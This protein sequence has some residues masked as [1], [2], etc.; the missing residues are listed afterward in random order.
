MFEP[1]VSTPIS[2]HDRARRVAQALVLLVGQRHRR[3]DG[4]RVAG[5]HAHR[6][7]VLDRADD[8]EVVGA[9]ADD[10]ELELLPAEQALL[11]QALV[12]RALLEAPS[13]SP[14]SN[15]LAS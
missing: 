1:P 12:R 15:S 14:S 3:R 6:V 13:G 4:D 2:V 7:D 9:V 11:D 10:L 8:D 5:V